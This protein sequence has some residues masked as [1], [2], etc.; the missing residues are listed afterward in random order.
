MQ[1]SRFDDNMHDRDSHVETFA[2]SVIAVILLSVREGRQNGL[3]DHANAGLH[4]TR[5]AML[6]HLL[7]KT[8]RDGVPCYCL[9]LDA[10]LHRSA[11]MVS[12]C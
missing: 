8:I 1:Q 11:S 10:D 2:L 12:A 5:E 9:K 3:E 6:D 4:G 7:A